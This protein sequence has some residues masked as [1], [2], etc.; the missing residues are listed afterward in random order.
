VIDSLDVKVVFQQLGR[1]LRS[2]E[3]IEPAAALGRHAA[4]LGRGHQAPFHRGPRS[5]IKP[6]GTP[7]AL[8]ASALITLSPRARLHAYRPSQVLVRLRGRRRPG[9]NHRRPRSGGPSYS[10]AHS[11]TSASGMSLSIRL[12]PKIPASADGTNGE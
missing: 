8:I 6:M 1:E 11:V 2:A 10:L 3:A 9:S 4:A 7:A 5:K 12:D